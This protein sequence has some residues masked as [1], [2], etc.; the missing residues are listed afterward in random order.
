MYPRIKENYSIKE[1]IIFNREMKKL[2]KI[3]LEMDI[4]N[5]LNLILHLIKEEIGK[6]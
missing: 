4:K 3:I 1:L 6:E 2:K 5:L